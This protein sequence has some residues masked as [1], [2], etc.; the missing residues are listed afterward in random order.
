MPGMDGYTICRKMKQLSKA[1]IAMLTGQSTKVDRARG[2]LAGCDDY[3][4]KPPVDDELRSVLSK[5]AL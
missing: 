4:M 2:N 5:A 1:R 3:L